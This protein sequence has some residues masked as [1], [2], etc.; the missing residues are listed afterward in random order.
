VIHRFAIVAALVACGRNEVAP[1]PAVV[2]APAIVSPPV[3]GAPE[4][5]LNPTSTFA[6]PAPQATCDE[7][8]PTP[9]AAPDGEPPKELVRIDREIQQ[10]RP[11]Y[12]YSGSVADVFGDGKGKQG[13][14]PLYVN[15]ALAFKQRY[16]TEVVEPLGAPDWAVVAI[17]HE[18]ELLERLHDSLAAV[19]LYGGPS[20]VPSGQIQAMTAQQQQLLMAMQNSGRPDLIAKAA[21]LYAGIVAFWM[22]KQKEE[23]EGIDEHIVKLYA[24]AAASKLIDNP[25][26]ARALRRIGHYTTVKGDDAMR[27][28]VPNYQALLMACIALDQRGAQ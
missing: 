27:K 5:P 17:T 24:R 18:A 20:P 8:D 1:P 15:E 2:E 14:Y 7:H 21:Q 13:Q 23:L 16:E 12:S 25:A 19:T 22:Q 28:L 3:V 6:T 10:T 26:R 9:S 11:T 4:A